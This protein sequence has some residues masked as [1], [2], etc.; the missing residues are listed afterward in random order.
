MNEELHKRINAD[1]RIHLV[2]SKEKGIYFLRFAVC[3][4][5]TESKDIAF[6]WA[7][8]VELAQKLIGQNGGV[9]NHE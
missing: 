8:I 9:A 3:A 4:R 2:P 5:N 7:T 1:G 6:A